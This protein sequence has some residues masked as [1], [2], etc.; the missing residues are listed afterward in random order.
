M[1]LRKDN[2]LARRKVFRRTSVL[3]PPKRRILTAVNKSLS[4]GLNQLGDMA[5]ILI[6]SMA[7]FGQERV[8]AVM[9]IIIPLGVQA[10]SSFSGAINDSYVIQIALSDEHDR[11]A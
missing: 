6:V 5:K 7:F 8:E 11:P 4:K 2:K 3:P 10:I 1:V 9:E